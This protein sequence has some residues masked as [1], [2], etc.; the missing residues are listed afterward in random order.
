[1]YLD[2][3]NYLP[4][5]I[6]VKMDR[7]SMAS[8]LETRAPFLDHRVAMMAWKM[9]SD[10]KIKEQNYKR[11]GKWP[12][13]K[14]LGNYIP[15]KLFNR[16]KAGFAIPLAEWLRGPLKPLLYDSINNLKKTNTDVLNFER[17]RDLFNCDKF[18]L[19]IT[20]VYN[21]KINDSKK[22]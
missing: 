1:M 2:T 3:L 16:P 15:P 9:S 10:L 6:L 8:S 14:I 4:N 13:R 17:V 19:Q 20:E 21:Y 11:V 5:D 18:T 22:L 7:A 12:L